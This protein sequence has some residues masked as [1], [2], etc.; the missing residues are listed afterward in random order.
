MPSLTQESTR[1]LR[2]PI[3]QR[4]KLSHFSLY[5]LA[6]TI[7]FNFDKGIVCLAGANG[8]GKSTFLQVVG[9][10]MTGVVPKPYQKFVSVDDYY[11]DIRAFTPDYFDGRIRPEHLEIAEIELEMLLGSTRITVVRGFVESESLRAAASS[12]RKSS[13]R[14]APSSVSSIPTQASRSSCSPSSTSSS[15]PASAGC[16]GFDLR[17]IRLPLGP[18]PA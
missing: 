6:D 13:M 8:L 16:P 10:G 14:W 17:W 18:S 3:L 1:K 15:R 5:P 12:E 9:Y 11:R 7:E 2:F 4:I